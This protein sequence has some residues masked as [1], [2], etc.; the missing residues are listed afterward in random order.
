MK[1]RM[2]KRRYEKLVKTLMPT[3]AV[4][5]ILTVGFTVKFW[6]TALQKEAEEKQVEVK[7][8]FDIDII[9]FI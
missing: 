4:L 7:R 3:I 8:I 9:K 6:N 1:D 2:D 5:M